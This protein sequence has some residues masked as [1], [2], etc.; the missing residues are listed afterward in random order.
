MRK[1]TAGLAVVCLLLPALLFAHGHGHV[2]GMITEAD[3]T[4]LKVRTKEG[5]TVPVPLN[6]KT[7]YFKG[8]VSAAFGD[9]K[10]G[11]RVVVHLGEDG[12]AMEV[13]LPSTA[14][15]SAAKKK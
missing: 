4:H 15:T 7:K 3:V 11:S 10:V 8:N 9:A 12:A 5:K 1:T 13:R 14:K 2:T 6:E